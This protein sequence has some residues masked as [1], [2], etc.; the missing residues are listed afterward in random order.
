ML[1]HTFMQVDVLTEAADVDVEVLG[2]PD[3]EEV[4][5]A[6]AEVAGAGDV[7]TAFKKTTLLRPSGSERL[8][9]VGLGKREDLSAERLRV[10]AAVALKQARALDASSLAWALPE[11][12]SSVELPVA[13]AAIVEGTILASYRFDRFHTSDEDEPKPPEIERLALLAP[14]GADAEAIAAEVRFAR[15]AADGANRA[16]ELQD[17]PA[18]ILNPT[19]LADRARQIAVA[20]EPVSVRR[21]RSCRDAGGRAWAASSP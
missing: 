7:K 17:L 5:S 21:D 3:G 16:R 4:P 11:S 8:L 15:T 13:A 6:I 19:Y 10:A 14:E 2:L 20:F 18:N 9:V 12:S 1:E